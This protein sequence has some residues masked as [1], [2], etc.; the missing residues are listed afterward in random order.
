MAG[1]LAQGLSQGWV[2]L[3]WGKTH[4]SAHSCRSQLLGGSWIRIFVSHD[5]WPKATLS[6]PCYMEL[7]SGQLTTWELSSSEKASK[8]SQRMVARQN[9]VFCYLISKVT[10][11]HLCYILFVR[12]KSVV[13]DGIPHGVSTRS[14]GSSGPSYEAA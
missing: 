3:N 12:R 10:S 13:L 7:S 4:C 1:S 8:K 14:Q 5:C 9:S 6:V 2:G 11:H